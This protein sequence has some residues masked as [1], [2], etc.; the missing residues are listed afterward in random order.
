[1]RKPSSKRKAQASVAPIRSS[2]R[3]I[4]MSKSKQY[5]ILFSKNYMNH[6]QYNAAKLY[7]D[8]KNFLINSNNCKL[9]LTT[10]GSCIIIIIL[11]ILRYRLN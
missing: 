1:M 6:I 2:G 10:V 11:F 8:N 5:K 7:L 4:T 9:F 3:C